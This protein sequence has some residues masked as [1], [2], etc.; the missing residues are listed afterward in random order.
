MDRKGRILATNLETY[1]LYVETRHLVDPFNTAHKLADLFDD[2]N[3]DNLYSQFTSKR[4]F[5]DKET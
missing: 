2:L 5:V 3:A 1:A 4:N